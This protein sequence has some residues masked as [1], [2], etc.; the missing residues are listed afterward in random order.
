MYAHENQTKGSNL[1]PT[2]SH[3]RKYLFKSKRKKRIDSE[4]QDPIFD[5]LFSKA[6]SE[7][8]NFNESRSTQLKAIDLLFDE[9]LSQVRAWSSSHADLI[10]LLSDEMKAIMALRL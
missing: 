6:A 1:D 8:T 5:D 3:Y 10:H 9:C 2:H 4:V 7:R